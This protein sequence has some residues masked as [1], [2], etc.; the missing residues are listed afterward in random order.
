[1]ISLVFD[2]VVIQ[3]ALSVS[4]DERCFVTDRGDISQIETTFLS[5][6]TVFKARVEDVPVDD[7]VR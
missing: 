5:S 4:L 1:M 7:F 2:M 3:A 6:S